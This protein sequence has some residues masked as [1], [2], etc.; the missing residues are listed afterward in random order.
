MKPV[1]LGIIGC[2]IAAQSLHWPVLQ[3]LK[4]KFEITAIVI[5]LKKRPKIFLKYWVE[6]LMFLIITI[7]YKDPM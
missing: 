2:G 4:D 6:Y 1:K 3:K 5:I 7:F